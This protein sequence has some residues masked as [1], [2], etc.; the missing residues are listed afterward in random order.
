MEKACRDMGEGAAR[1]GVGDMH[2]AVHRRRRPRDDRDCAGLDR[3]G[4]EILAIEFFAGEGAE[5]RSRRDLAMVDR[6]PGDH[7]VR[8]RRL[9]IVEQ[10]GEAH[11][12]A[13][14]FLRSRGVSSDT[15]TSRVSSGKTPS[16]GPARITILRTTGAA[17]HP[18]V[19]WPEL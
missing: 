8:S 4:N 9:S 3:G 6:K 7:R 12:S 11:Y 13:S 16:I 17:V 10:R 2:R 15:S 1:V 18:A 19:R 5:D 14:S